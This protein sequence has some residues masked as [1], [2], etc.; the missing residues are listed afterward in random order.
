M[1]TESDLDKNI[2]ASLRK[3]VAAFSVPP[4]APHTAAELRSRRRK[5]RMA[6]GAAVCMLALPVALGAT[7]AISGF[8]RGDNPAAPAAPRPQGAPG[9]CTE[10]SI[11]ISTEQTRGYDSP[12]AAVAE[13]LNEGD[14]ITDVRT[15]PD[16]G[17]AYVMVALAE[18]G[19]MQFELSEHE[20]LWRMTGSSTCH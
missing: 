8:D 3:D 16:G 7:H 19:H 12:E 9:T 14:E 6:V 2:V 20:S 4:S 10:T 1:P 17:L 13:Y 15:D 5:R 11:F 18:G